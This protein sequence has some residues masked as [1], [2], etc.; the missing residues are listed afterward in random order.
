MTLVY[1]I[2]TRIDTSIFK[3]KKKKIMVNRTVLG[4]LQN[5]S[6]DTNPVHI[7]LTLG[8]L[9]ANKLILTECRQYQVKR[10]SHN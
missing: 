3:K 7:R 10:L 9:T 4:I 2:G 1:G 5:Y 6:P 8:F